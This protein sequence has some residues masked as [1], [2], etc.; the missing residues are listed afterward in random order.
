LFTP[1]LH[2]VHFDFLC[3]DFIKSLKSIVLREKNY[4]ELVEIG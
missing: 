4:V 1:S 2:I 3:F